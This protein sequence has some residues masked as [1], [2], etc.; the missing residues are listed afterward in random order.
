MAQLFRLICTKVSTVLV[1]LLL[2]QGAAAQ[3]NFSD[4]DSKLLQYQ[5]QLG[6]NVVTLIYKDGKMIYAKSLGDFDANTQAPIASCS[7]W[8][9]AALVMTFV[10]EGK[11]SL[12]D[13]VSKYLPIFEQYGKGYITIR[14][15]LSHT[16]G[17]EGEPVGLRSIIK[18]SKYKSLEDEVNDFAGKHNIETNPGV[19]FRYSTIG[20]NIAGRVLEV[21]SKRPFDRLMQDRI[22]RP[23]AMR[24][25]SFST[26]Y[27]RAVNPSGGAVSSANDYMNF[28]KMLMNKG[29]FNGKKV[30][31]EHAIQ[32]MQQAQTT[33]PIIKYA[34]EAAKGFNYALGEWVQEEDENGKSVVVSSPGLF[35]TWPMIDNCRGYA[36]IVFVKSLISEEKAN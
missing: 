33:L 35:G 20:L 16:T 5:K 17:I 23:L 27:E 19:E 8:L 25:S 4:L 10:D 13:K 3:Y 32:I 11:L 21:L 2:L 6:N 18:L 36:C 22:F 9:T 15:C 29:M 34:P 30:L 12:D 31:S 7:K 28:L 1:F 24:N 14:Q 26:D